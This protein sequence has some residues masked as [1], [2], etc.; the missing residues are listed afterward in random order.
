MRVM[1]LVSVIAHAFIFNFEMINRG[2][3]ALT[4]MCAA[5]RKAPDME[6]KVSGTRH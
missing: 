4:H 3:A 5:G 2:R 1:H 6:E